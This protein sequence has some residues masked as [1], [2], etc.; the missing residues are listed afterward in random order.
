MSKET[1]E[2]K[3]MVYKAL[4]HPI[5][6]AIVDFLTDGEQCV[7]EIVKYT[8]AEQ[9]NVSR[10]LRV[11]RFAGVVVSRQVVHN[12]FYELAMPSVVSLNAAL[13]E[14]LTG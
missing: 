8:E 12:V 2:H 13:T 1:L 4:G 6:L 5:R 3:A 9:S 7:Q 11:L 10:H 14:D